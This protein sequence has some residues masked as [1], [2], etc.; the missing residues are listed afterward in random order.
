MINN[1][2][3]TTKGMESAQK[4]LEQAKNRV[5]MEK[6]K[7]N[8][9]RRKAENRHKYMMGGVVHK[10]FPECYCFEEDEMNEIIKV[11]FK[12]SEV[13]KTISNIKDRAN[14]QVL[15]RP[16]ESKVNNDEQNR[17]ESY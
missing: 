6:K 15:S 17:T 9:E 16:V 11:A 2:I 10:Y 7:A 14:G 1:E 13:Q 8:E 4:A 3:T 5:A 12:T